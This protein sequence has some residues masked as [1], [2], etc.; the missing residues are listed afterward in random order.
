MN[1]ND[2]LRFAVNIKQNIKYA[3]E[4]QYWS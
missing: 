4:P 2:I 1:Y 3:A